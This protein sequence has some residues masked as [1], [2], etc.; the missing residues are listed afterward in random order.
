MA[1]IHQRFSVKYEACGL[2]EVF[3]ITTM[4]PRVLRPGEIHFQGAEKFE[5]RS[6][7][8]ASFHVT[9]PRSRSDPS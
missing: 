8:L 5:A 6:D 2:P 9:E 4:L 3:F 1:D 7:P